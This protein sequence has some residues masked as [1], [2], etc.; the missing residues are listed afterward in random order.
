MI[1][2]L[3]SKGDWQSAYDR[4]KAANLVLRDDTYVA[5]MLAISAMKVEGVKSA[6]AIGYFE[7]LRKLEKDHGG[8]GIWS[9]GNLV[10]AALGLAD[11]EE[12]RELLKQLNE[13]PDAHR[14][15]KSIARYF[16][17]IIT[18]QKTAQKDFEFDWLHYWP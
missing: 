15:K 5:N 17:E 6:S 7:K 11:T 3:I 4:L 10:N 12:A 9:L 2:S 8:R 18:A 16:D 14:N 13:M 1:Q